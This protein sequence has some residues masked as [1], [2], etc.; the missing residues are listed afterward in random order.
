MS[1]DELMNRAQFLDVQDIMKLFACGR[2]VAYKRIQEIKAVSD[3]L[4][5]RGKVTISDYEAWYNS[6]LSDK[7]QEGV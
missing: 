4:R 6:P 7:P 1:K 3:I 2:G 5:L